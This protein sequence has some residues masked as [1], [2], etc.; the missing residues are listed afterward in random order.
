MNETHN[1]LLDGLPG[2][3]L[4]LRGMTDLAA[5]KES[6]ESQLVQIASTRLSRAGIKI[7]VTH[8]QAL[9]AD[10]RLYRLL[11]QQHGN[12][13][14]SQYNAFIRQLVS[15]ERALDQRIAKVVTD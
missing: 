12:E 7:P 14:H 9:N 13:A 6:V 4:I 10:H 3:D 5:G 11:G 8:E 1:A 2:A 15:F